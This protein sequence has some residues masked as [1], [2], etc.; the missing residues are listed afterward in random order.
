MTLYEIKSWYNGSVLFSVETDN[1]E[2]AIKAAIKAQ[3]D[4]SGANLSGA[5]LSGADLYGAN[6][7]GANLSGADL[8]GANLSGANLYGANL[9]RAYHNGCTTWPAGFD[10]GR[11]A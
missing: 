9:S 8:S 4:L 7:Y 10:K 6:L 2:N 1:L 5:D 11:L 3:A